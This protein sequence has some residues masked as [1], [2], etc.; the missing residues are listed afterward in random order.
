MIKI[1]AC[2]LVISP[3]KSGSYMFNQYHKPS[4][5]MTKGIK[6]QDKNLCG[7]ALYL[8]PGFYSVHIDERKKHRY[9][10]NKT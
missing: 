6:E 3:A 10:E 4:C 8:S 7:I 9:L 1:S 2:Q 5:L